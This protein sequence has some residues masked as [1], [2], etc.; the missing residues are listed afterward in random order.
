M[1]RVI[2]ITL[3]DFDNVLVCVTIYVGQIMA[4]NYDIN[5]LNDLQK[6]IVYDTDGAIL[7]SAGA[8]SGKTRLL[9]HR[10]AY[11]IDKCGVNQS[12]ILAITFTNKAANEM[13]A[14]VEKMLGIPCYVWMST[15]HSM[16]A[17]I[18][19][20]N[21][22]LIDGYSRYFTIYDDTDSRKLVKAII[23]DFNL[24]DVDVDNIIWHISNAKNMG[25]DALQYSKEFSFYK[26]IDTITKVFVEYDSRLK[27]S[28][29]LDFDDLL[30]KMLYLLNNFASVREYY[31]DRFKYI[32][33][34]EFQDTNLV[35]YKIVKALAGKHGNLFVVGD[36][37][38]SIY[39]WRGAHSGIIR[40]FMADF[41]GC[42]VYKMEQNYRSTKSI[43]DS[44]NMLIK[45]NTS[46][47]DKT[48]FTDNVQGEEVSLNVAYDETEECDNVAKKI[49]LLIENGVKYSEIGVFIRISALSR[50]M[51]EKLLN[52]DIPYKVSGIFKFFE[53]AEIKNILAY[54][55]LAVNEYDSV[56]FER[57]VNF[58]KRGIGESSVEQ[59]RT[60]S[61]ASGVS[62][63]EVAM[64]PDKYNLPSSLVTKITPFG[65]VM[66]ELVD[67]IDSMSLTDWVDNLLKVTGINMQ[68]N[69]KSEEDINRKLNVDSFEHSVATFD[70]D[71]DGA[72]VVDYLQSV[73]LAND[74]N[75][76]NSGDA[77]S[78]F[79]I[80]AAKGLEFD[81][82]F[83]IG[84]EEGIF[85]LSRALDEPDELEEERRLMYV[86]ITRAKRKLY[87]SY[88]RS[89]FLYGK[90]NNMAAS[91]FIKE[92]GMIKERPKLTQFDNNYNSFNAVKL[93]KPNMMPD[94]TDSLWQNKISNQKDK[95]SEYKVGELVLHPK[96]G[97]GSIIKTEIIGD[98]S[99][100]TVDYNG[101]GVK[102]LS[103]AFA[104]LQIIKKR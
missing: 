93:N 38:Q 27:Q 21:I 9:T 99:Y 62:M 56:A 95:F 41:P 103:L 15:F 42:K 88:A 7:V 89:R 81:Y 4:Y 37:D 69:T 60:A 77:V 102:T 6:K 65:Q 43:L 63:R 36:E 32:L 46:R 104:P 58:P 47:M 75:D 71:N 91:R 3:I 35:Q 11:M 87:L 92:M 85:P 25:Y 73:T 17:R 51:E 79:T 20:E 22:S 10:I 68:Y 12:E 40:D 96:F 64:H 39:S 74:L 45:H 49:S 8:G 57:I 98:N 23:K 48:L 59:I 30:T 84:L 19:R 67:S 44:A 66:H 31:Q 100:V 50:L 13:K 5:D 82:V 24:D 72:T 2:F 14:R 78:L 29:A 18:L 16:C 52:Y 54:M 86:A 28:N 61:I 34:D 76:E 26:D 1:F 94:S 97:V 80:H 83:V 101:V 33:V 55:T 53:R 70:H 90:R